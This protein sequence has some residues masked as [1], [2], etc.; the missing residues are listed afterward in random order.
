MIGRATRL[1]LLGLTLSG[2]L[3]S[4][5]AQSIPVTA[6]AD[7]SSLVGVTFDLPIDIDMSGRS[8]LLGSFALSLRWNPAVLELVG[9]QEGDFGSVT[10]NQDSLPFGV[11][12]AS[13]VIRESR[14]TAA[15]S[16]GCSRIREHH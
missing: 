16:P 5:T 2:M 11:L 15:R 8:E 4:A 13:G 7:A 14:R 9:G 10:V 3:G 12:L 6:G 1:G